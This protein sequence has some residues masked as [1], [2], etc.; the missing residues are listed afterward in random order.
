MISV[1][2]ITN[3]PAK[4][5]ER[6]LFQA[7]DPELDETALRGLYDKVMYRVQGIWIPPRNRLVREFG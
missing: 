2:T 3:L 7:T 6:V 4:H 1:T 5:T